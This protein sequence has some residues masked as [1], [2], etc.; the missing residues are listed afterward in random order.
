MTQNNILDSHGGLINNN[1]GSL[2][3][4]DEND[5]NDEMEDH[6]T[7]KLSEYY[8]T[9]N[10]SS[11]TARNHTSINIMSFNA[12]SIWKKLD[13]LKIQLDLFAALN[14]TIHII[15]VQE[16]WVNNMDNA[17]LLNIENYTTFI[18]PNQI[19]GQKGG[20]VTYVHNSL[21]ATK[22]TF[23]EPSK[24]NLWEGLSLSLE[25]ELLPTPIT[26]HT[27]YRPPREKSGLRAEHAI[28]NHKKFID[29]FKPY[30]ESLKSSTTNNILLGDL[31]YNLLEAATNSKV[32]EYFDLLIS[33]EFIP[34]IT[35]PT[36]INKLSC[37]LYDHIF[38][39]VNQ[40]LIL[41]SGI[42]ITSLSD[43][44]PTFLSISAISKR[45]QPKYKTKKDFSE[46]NMKKVINKLEESMQQTKFET[47]LTKDPNI[48]HSLLTN[49]IDSAM[50]EIPTKRIKITKYNTKHSPWITQGLLN[51]IRT[52]D[53]LYKQL[54]NCKRS[55]PS[56]TRKKEK[57][58]NHK[59]LL[60]K[61]IRK[62][63]KDYYSS[64]FI[65]FANDCKSTWKLINQVAG[66]K[67]INKSS[68]KLLRQI[69][70]GPRE[71]GKHDPLYIEFTT[72]SS[73]AE[74]FNIHYANVGPNLFKKIQYN[75]TKTV[76]SYL[77][78]P[79]STH[80]EFKA[81]TDE[82]VLKIISEILP[83]N[84]S[85]YDNLTS[86][87]LKQFAPII[88]PAIRL[89][90]N[91]S[92]F[93]G[94]FPQNLKHAIVAPIYKGKNSD[95]KEFVNYRP[96]SL[97]PT[98]SKVIEKVVQKQLYLYMNDNNLFTDSQYGFRTNHSTEHAAVEFVDRIAQKL[99]E[100]EV[101]FTIFIDL[102][103]AFDT[104][105]HTILLRKL[106]YYGIRGTALTWF[107]S[108]L[109]GRTQSVK[110]NDVISDPLTLQTGVPQGSVLGPLLFLIYINDII[111]ASRLLKEIL[112]ADDTSLTSTLSAFYVYKP[113]TKNDITILSNSINAELT[114][115]TDWLKINK[116][117][118][119]EDKTKYMIFHTPRRNMEIYETLSIKMNNLSIKRVKSFNFLGI[120]VNE[121]LTWTDH[122]AH[123]SQKISPV[124][125]L[126]HRLKK[127]LPICILKTIY[128]SLILSRLHY[129]NI[130]WGRTPGHLIKTHKKALRA[131]VG[132]AYNAHTTPI[133]KKLQI[134]S[135]PDLHN[136]KMLCYYKK[137]L[138]NKLPKYISQMFVQI[139]PQDQPTPP[140]TKIYEHTIRFQLHIYLLTAPDYL[141]QQ[142]HQVSFSYLKYKAKK[143]MIERYS[144]L[145][146]KTG[147]QVCHMSY[148]NRS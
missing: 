142:L 64:Q 99:D 2:L 132:A 50:A 109:T 60:N 40:N 57:H 37:N 6:I 131:I 128:S 121:T 102:S 110:F 27:V 127:L 31:N 138:E 104:L 16:S 113:K 73:I 54:M 25:G 129:G 140:R 49:I 147:C 82:D 34:Q 80:F 92:L 115:I 116:L 70:Q 21:N 61:L 88:H 29:E 130:L 136:T 22:K 96:I 5:Y 91:Q 48:N 125:S 81:V 30:I 46:I 93:T 28:E 56:Y 97:L 59:I 118:L 15:T 63:K 137:Y 101:P 11:Y 122:I 62:T 67:A 86:K 103:K 9:E 105:D 89:L 143:Y 45:P 75:G 51:S 85:G 90:I 42:F 126:L 1:L 38:T 145:C 10:I 7:F 120:I 35:A 139:D 98:L 8:D 3:H 41:D 112:F 18:Q 133:Q 19:G 33:N 58:Q 52:R 77:R 79:A 78:A 44:L 74:A 32:Q 14:H 119:N 26:I 36:K 72:N 87:A 94:I 47:C 111:H 114:K 12:E 65:I 4:L 20:I 43:H 66:R 107:K 39:K 135:L 108:Y 55:S 71:E 134:L 124:I 84:S 148:I 68:P 117:S 76:E 17:A 83:K 144:S 141:I 146:T 53:R 13:N 23:F 100:G 95:P 24:N 106:Q 123:L 69:A